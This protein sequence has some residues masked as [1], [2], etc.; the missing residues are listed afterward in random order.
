M[1]YAALL[2]LVGCVSCFAG[3][4]GGGPTFAK[5]DIYPQKWFTHTIGDDFCVAIQNKSFTQQYAAL[6]K[7]LQRVR[8]DPSPQAVNTWGR[9]WQSCLFSES[10][11]LARSSVF[12]FKFGHMW[13]IHVAGILNLYVGTYLDS[14]PRFQSQ[15]PNFC[16]LRLASSYYEVW[17][18]S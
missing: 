16:T 7:V 5:W 9:C 2:C 13:H 11:G 8:S 4:F 17:N 15:Q 1:R 10:H 6:F 12:R 18:A 14:D 3:G